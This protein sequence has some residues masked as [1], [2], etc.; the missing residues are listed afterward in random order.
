MYILRSTIFAYLKAE[1][2]MILGVDLYDIDE[3]NIPR[4]K[5]KHAITVTGFSVQNNGST[6]NHGNSIKLRSSLIDKIYVHDDQVGPFSKMEFNSLPLD[7]GNGDRLST[8]STEWPSEHQGGRVVAVPD[9]LMV[10]L[11]HKIRIQFGTV[12]DYIWELDK[13]FKLLLEGNEDLMPVDGFE[14]SIHL[15]TVNKYKNGLTQTNHFPNE[16]KA[17]TL[18]T[19]LPKFI[20]VARAYSSNGPVID[21]IFDVTD[22]DQGVYFVHALES[23]QSLSSYL[24]IILSSDKILDR[25]KSSKSYEVIGW[26]VKNHS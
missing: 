25:I 17:K 5:G 16:D 13:L 14:W 9:I 15:T 7:L 20:W 11:Y 10:P 22:L 3:N 24:Q 2:P 18:L 23:C 1:I 8:L 6:D 21:L 26:L 12:H 19:S 4:L